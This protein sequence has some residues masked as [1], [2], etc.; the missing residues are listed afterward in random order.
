MALTEERRA[1]LMEQMLVEVLFDDGLKLSSDM[2]REICNKAPRLGMKQ[3]EMLE[4]A[5]YLIPKV[6]ERTVKSLLEKREKCKRQRKQK[7]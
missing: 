6:A 2:K 7:R 5:A 4:F 3:E 1:E